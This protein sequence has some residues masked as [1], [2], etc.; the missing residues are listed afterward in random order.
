MKLSNVQSNHTHTHTEKNTHTHTHGCDCEW[1]ERMEGWECVWER[2]ALEVETNRKSSFVTLVSEPVWSLC[3]MKCVRMCVCVSL[4][5]CVGKWSGAPG[6]EV[7]LFLMKYLWSSLHI[8]CLRNK[9]W[10]F[11]NVFIICLSLFLAF[12]LFSFE[13]LSFSLFSF[14]SLSLCLLTFPHLRHMVIIVTSQT[15]VSVTL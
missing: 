9:A 11:F 8:I 12:F 6:N 14:S 7:C 13:W 1:G 3:G 4:C 5:V 15:N 10:G 2:V